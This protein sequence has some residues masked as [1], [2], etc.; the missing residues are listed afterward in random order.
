V[1]YLKNPA[2]IVEPQT[3]FVVFFDA[4]QGLLKKSNE[5][6]LLIWRLCDGEHD[7]ESMAE[8]VLAAYPDANPDMVH[9]DVRAFLQELQQCNFIAL[10]EAQDLIHEA[11]A[12][13]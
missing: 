12:S 13:R 10:I 2:V 11:N 1:K 6:G 3:D 8:A 4:E 7:E 5:V 9:R